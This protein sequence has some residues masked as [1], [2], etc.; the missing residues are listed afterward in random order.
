MPGLNPLIINKINE[1]NSLY[2]NGNFD[3]AANYLLSILNELDEDAGG[4]YQSVEGRLIVMSLYKIFF[5]QGNFVEAKNGP[6][7]SLILMFLKKQP[8]S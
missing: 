4:R 8:L 1:A 6:K 3:G 5:A 7:M 2:A